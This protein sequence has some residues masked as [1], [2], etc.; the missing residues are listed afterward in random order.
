MIEVGTFVAVSIA[1][2]EYFG[3]VRERNGGR[4]IMNRNQ[5]TFKYKVE[6]LDKFNQPS[7]EFKEVSSSYI[8]EKDPPKINQ[9]EYD[10]YM[11]SKDP[12]RCRLDE[13]LADVFGVRDDTEPDG[14]PVDDDDEY[15]Y[16]LWGWDDFDYSFL[17]YGIEGCQVRFFETEL[18]QMTG[19]RRNLKNTSKLMIEYPGGWIPTFLEDLNKLL[20]RYGQPL[21]PLINGH[22]VD[23][24]AM[25]RMR[26]K[27]RYEYE[28]ARG[29]R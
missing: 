24:D 27:E 26:C 6:L 22:T 3:I 29:L 7:G 19:K 21:I 14:E 11:R 2:K 4:I 16:T 1:Q 9:A 18:L 15:G 20:G 25:L 8:M 10:R 23:T 28:K 12:A 5:A 13:G 17:R